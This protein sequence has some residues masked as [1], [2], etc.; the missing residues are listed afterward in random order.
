VYHHPFSLCGGLCLGKN[1]LGME[2]EVVALEGFE[3]FVVG[4]GE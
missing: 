4:E 2:G 1:D 3:E